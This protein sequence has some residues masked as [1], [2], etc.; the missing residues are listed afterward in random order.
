VQ[1]NIDTIQKDNEALLDA[2]QEVGMEVN[3]EKTKYMLMSHKKV[4]QKHSIKIAKK[5]FQDVAKFKYLGTT[6]TYENLKHEEI[7]SSLNSGNTC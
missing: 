4:G 5:S 2:R 6:L 3:P 1:E 7:K